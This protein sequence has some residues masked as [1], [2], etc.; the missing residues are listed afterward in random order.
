MNKPEEVEA[1]RKYAG[2]RNLKIISTGFYHGWCDQ[3]ID[4]DPVNL[5]AYFKHATEVITDTFHGSVMSIITGAK[6]AVKTRESNHFKLMNLLN[7]YGLSNR[8]FTKWTD[9]AETMNPEINYDKVNNEV[10]KRRGESM[11]IL[12]K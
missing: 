7:E 11:T 2:S 8:I 5:L 10:E 1:I 9:I 4:V 3:N 12:S 6:F